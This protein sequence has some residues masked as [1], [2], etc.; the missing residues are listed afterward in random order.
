MSDTSPTPPPEASPDTCPQAAGRSKFQEGASC[1][2][3]EGRLAKGRS[4]GALGIAASVPAGPR[5]GGH[6]GSPM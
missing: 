4:A 2:W 3:A 5:L 6:P 1:R